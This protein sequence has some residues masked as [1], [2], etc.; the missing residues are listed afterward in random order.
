MSGYSF[1]PTVD[2]FAAW[3]QTRTGQQPIDAEGKVH[4]DTP[5]MISTFE[6]LQGLVSSGVS[7]KLPPRRRPA[8]L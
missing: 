3:S 4:L 7:P 5:E 1:F 6:F 8:P 2:Q